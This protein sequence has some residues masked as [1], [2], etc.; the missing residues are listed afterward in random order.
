MSANLGTVQNV[1]LRE[2]W[3][4]EA[5]D[6]TPWLAENL[7]L[8]AQAVGVHFEFENK[9][10]DVG[11]YKADIVA[12]VPEDG[13]RVIIENQLEQADLQHLGQVLAYLAGL[14]AR[15]VIWVAKGFRDAHLTAIRWLNDHTDDEF[16]FFAVQVNVVRIDNSRPAPLFDVVE[17]P[18]EWTREVHRQ[19][20]ITEVGEFRRKFWQ[21]FSSRLPDAQGLKPGYAGSNVWHPLRG[22]ELTVVQFLA[23]DRVGVYVS[24]KWGESRES[25]SPRIEAFAAALHREFSDEGVSGT[26]RGCGTVLR[27]DTRD[28]KNWGTMADWLDERRQIYEKVLRNGPTTSS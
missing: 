1:D 28:E 18:N 26:E 22:L 4:H 9:E 7:E 24:G 15:I 20:D 12:R 14:E 21:F 6:F 11:G 19:E 10:V 25:A 23:Q 13:A 5:H 2:A 16:A 8:L 27:I 3:Q 17:R